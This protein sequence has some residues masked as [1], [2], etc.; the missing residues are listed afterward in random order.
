MHQYNS[1]TMP[2]RVTCR[3][4]ILIAK[5]FFL[6]NNTLL[7][8]IGHQMDCISFH[9]WPLC[10][11]L[12]CR[13]IWYREMALRPEQSD[14][15]FADDIFK[16]SFLND[17]H[18]I[19]FKFH[20]NLLL[21]QSVTIDSGTWWLGDRATSQCQNDPIHRC[22]YASPSLNE[23]IYIYIYIYMLTN[24]DLWRF[25]H[26]SL[27]T[28]IVEIR[29]SYHLLPAMVFH[30]MVSGHIHIETIKTSNQSEIKKIEM[31]IIGDINWRATLIRIIFHRSIW[32]W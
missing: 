5:G 8:F 26:N 29:S 21:V 12:K 9:V 20:Q 1:S 3:F 23:F 30:I 6:S 14:H 11:S 27:Y 18:V 4:D 32:P 16:C 28:L 7:I 24:Q 19:W 15:H 22:I 10:L 31:K 17:S 25:C 2:V 13:K